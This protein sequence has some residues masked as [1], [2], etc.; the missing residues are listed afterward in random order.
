MNNHQQLVQ[1]KLFELLRWERLKRREAI[2]VAALVYSVA[3]SLLMLP[4]S[5]LFPLWARPLSLTPLL[6]LI[7]M[8]ALMLA[9][10]W[11]NRET[12]Q[13]VLRLDRT[14]RLQEGAVT[15]WEILKR[16]VSKLPE[17]LVLEETAA[18][19]K[20]VDVRGLFARQRSW[21]LYAAPP[22][23]LI[24]ALMAWFGVDFHLDWGKG[25]RDLTMAK[26]IKDYSMSLQDKA[27]EENLTESL[28][29]ARALEE[30]ADKGLRGMVDEEELRNDLTDVAQGIGDRLKAFHGGEGS[31]PKLSKEA[32]KNLKSQVG[33]LKDALSRPNAFPGKGMRGGDVLKKFDRLD[34]FR[35]EMGNNP[36]SGE[37]M[38][39]NQLREFIEQL[40]RQ[41]ATEMDRRSLMEAE[42]F[43][44]LMLDGM[45]G[46]T[47]RPMDRQSPMASSSPSKEDAK[48]GSQPGDQ[49][50]KK[51]PEVQYPQFRAQAETHL[52][53]LFR[54]GPSAGVTLRGE[55]RA[56]DSEVPQEEIVTS[57]QR[58]VEGEL[59]AEQIP[60]DMRETVRNY[61][62][63][64]G[65]SGEQ[66]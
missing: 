57:Y 44:V 12:L 16:P 29:V 27:K 3:A 64:L 2:L 42:Q 58:Q 38:D 39:E 9:H 40:N 54:E 20:S 60:Q 23:L 36:S 15:A 62:L 1:E 8:L 61:F 26:K 55:F 41:A 4:L 63:S 30:V 53:G 48:K 5:D 22:V 19:L 6:F 52:K 65:M 56:K 13:A 28:D 34:P 66:Q 43:V 45:D 10:P 50:G 24:W 25:S 49:P 31:L 11:G 59:S 33:D 35:R 32:L 14:L 17:Q 46:E 18:R 47:T 7:S 37:S 51:G 21:H